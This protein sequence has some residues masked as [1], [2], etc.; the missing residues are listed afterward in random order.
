MTKIL[1]LEARFYND[2]GDTLLNGATTV[3]DGADVS[4]DRVTLPGAYEI[5]AALNLAIQN[6]GYAGYL[7][8]G[9]VI[10]GQTTHYD[11]ICDSVF[12]SVQDLIIAQNA[13]VGMGILTVESREQAEIRADPKQKNYGGKAAKALLTMLDVKKSLLNKTSLRAAS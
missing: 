4:Y 3:L 8:L 11:H 13:S 9:C 12:Q 7:L 6:G 1:I 10:R 5:P 2:I